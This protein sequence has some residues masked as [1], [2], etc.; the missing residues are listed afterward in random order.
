[1]LIIICTCFK[2]FPKTY[3]YYGI[4]LFSLYERRKK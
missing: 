1:M 2:L 4:I 3:Y